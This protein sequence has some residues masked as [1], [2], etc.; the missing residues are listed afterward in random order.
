M[1]EIDYRPNDAFTVADFFDSLSHKTG[2]LHLQTDYVRGRSMKTDMTIREDGSV[3]L[4]TLAPSAERLAVAGPPPR[5]AV[6]C[7]CRRT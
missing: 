1:S 6:D 2:E 7:P 4:A 5:Q 3:T